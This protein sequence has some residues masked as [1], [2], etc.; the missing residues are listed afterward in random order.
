MR[1]LLKPR[2]TPRGILLCRRYSGRGG[3]RGTLCARAALS[4]YGGDMETDHEKAQYARDY[5]WSR[6]VDC[7]T[8]LAS[9][10]AKECGALPWQCRCPSRTT[11]NC[12]ERC[13][14]SP[15]GSSKGISP[16]TLLLL[17]AAGPVRAL[18]QLAICAVLD[19]YTRCRWQ[20]LA[21]LCE[22]G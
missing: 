5:R 3:L 9:V 16:R 19:P 7:D 18:G 13:R 1:T 4:Q 2:L 8:L 21:R 17:L 20:A 14:R 11:A 22:S 10:V 12:D 15:K 6:V